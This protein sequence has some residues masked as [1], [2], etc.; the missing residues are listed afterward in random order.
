VDDPSNYEGIEKEGES[1]RSFQFV[2]S[3]PFQGESRTHQLGIFMLR[4]DYGQVLLGCT[5]L[6]ARFEMKT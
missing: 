6:F 2:S 5:G 1:S 3:K 4:R